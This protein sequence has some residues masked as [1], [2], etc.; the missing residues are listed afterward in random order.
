LVEGLVN[1]TGDRADFVTSNE[2]LSRKVIPQLETSLSPS[3]NE[4]EIHVSGHNSIEISPFPLLPITKSVSATYFVKLN[5]P[6]EVESVLMSGDLCGERQ[7]LLIEHRRT[8]LDDR[9]LSSL[10]ASETLRCLERDIN[11]P[12]PW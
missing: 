12:G 7:D 11:Q 6:A 10:Y 5:G 3:L 4:V 9:L 8:I 1:T 2:D